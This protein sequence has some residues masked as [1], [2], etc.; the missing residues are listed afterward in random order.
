L[1]NSKNKAPGIDGITAE[2]IQKPGPG[3]EFTYLL[4]TYGRNKKCQQTEEQV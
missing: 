2:L 1:I 4:S 3:A